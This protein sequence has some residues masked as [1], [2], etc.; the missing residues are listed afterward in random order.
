LWVWVV[1]CCGG[2]G[3]GGRSFFFFLSG[4]FFLCLFVFSFRFFSHVP[5]F[6][7]LFAD[8]VQ[9]F[10]VRQR[11]PLPPAIIFYVFLFIFYRPTLYGN[12]TRAPYENLVCSR[13]FAGPTHS[14]SHVHYKTNFACQFSLAQPDSGTSEK[15]KK[16]KKKNINIA[17]RQFVQLWFSSGGN[18][19]GP[20]SFTGRLAA[21][22]PSPSRVVE[23]EDRPLQPS[24][25]FHNRA[26]HTSTACRGSVSYHRP[27]DHLSFQV[28][29]ASPLSKHRRNEMA[30]ILQAL[31]VT[32]DG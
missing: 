5:L 9:L 18:V 26:P 11:L 17:P 27:H 24:S 29:A 13:I 20:A 7:Y 23:L 22:G 12:R 30:N 8:R 1:G 14:P 32:G 25:F 15:K 28:T 4:P 3:F 19:P 6:F 16:K 2:G 31:F 21:A 10:C